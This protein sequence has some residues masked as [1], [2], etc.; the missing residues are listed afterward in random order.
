[1]G[2]GV[3]EPLEPPLATPLRI[4]RFALPRSPH[5]PPYDGILAT[6]LHMKVNRLLR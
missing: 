6:P 1:M 5:C 3:L 2:G 4:Y